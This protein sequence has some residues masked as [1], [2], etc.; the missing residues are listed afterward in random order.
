M[1]E[2]YSSVVLRFE[3]LSISEAGVILSNTTRH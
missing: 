3:G 2:K 1:S